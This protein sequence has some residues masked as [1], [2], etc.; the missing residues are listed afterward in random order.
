[1]PRKRYSAEQIVTKLR[2]IKVRV[3]Q[4]RTIRQTCKETEITEQSYYRWRNYRD[5]DVCR[6]APPPSPTSAKGAQKMGWL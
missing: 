5:S 1:M 4:G 3:A 2:Q 6:V